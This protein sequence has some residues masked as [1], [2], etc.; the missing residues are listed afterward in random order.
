MRFVA[1][2]CDHVDSDLHINTFFFKYQ[3]LFP[4]RSIFHLT[5]NTTTQNYFETLIF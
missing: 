3:N 5:T 1:C 2:A 4:P